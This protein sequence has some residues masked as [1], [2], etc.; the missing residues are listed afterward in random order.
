MLVIHVLFIIPTYLGGVP[1]TTPVSLVIPRPNVLDST[2]VG[3][4]FSVRVV[5]ASSLN[6]FI[7]SAL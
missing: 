7:V 5:I 4:H 3:F 1:S 2:L 6:V